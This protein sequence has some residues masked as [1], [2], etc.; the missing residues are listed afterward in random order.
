MGSE[1]SLNG[2]GLRQG[3]PVYLVPHFDKEG[4]IDDWL[5]TK[6]VPPDDP[7]APKCRVTKID[8]KAKSITI[9]SY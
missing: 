5:I 6:E 7:D 8:H 1:F 3:D 2:H 4:N 9:S